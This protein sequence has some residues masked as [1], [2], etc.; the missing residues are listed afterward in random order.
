LAALTGVERF[1]EQALSAIRY[2]RSL[3][4]ADRG[5]WPDLRENMG[6]PTA[7]GQ[8]FAVTWCHGAPGIGLSRALCHTHLDD[9]ETLSEIAA[10]VRATMARGLVGNHSLCHGDLGNLE[11]LHQ[12]AI[13]LN[14]SACRSEVERRAGIILE[15][16]Q[17]DGWLC[18]NPSRFES[19][20][21][22][23]GLAGIGYGLLR[24]A[25]PERIP[26]VLALASP[27]GRR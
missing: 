21:L 13:V 11:F 16:I 2:E 25:S 7:T 12:A 4:S 9:A 20:G 1:R 18:G 17:R 14:D 27:V 5:N 19:P 3:F 22:M 15:S 10:A 24:L 26:S 23:T 8:G 6:P